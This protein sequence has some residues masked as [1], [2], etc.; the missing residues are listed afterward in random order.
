MEEQLEQKGFAIGT[1]MDIEGTFN[2][3]SGGHQ[4]GHDYTWRADCC[5][6]W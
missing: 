2:H 1:F 5:G 6:V 3:T 4:G